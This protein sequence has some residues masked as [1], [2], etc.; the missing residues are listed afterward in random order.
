MLTFLFCFALLFQ[1]VPPTETNPYL[2]QAITDEGDFPLPEDIKP[3]LEKFPW[4]FTSLKWSP[5]QGP[6]IT[7]AVL[8]VIDDTQKNRI[9][10]VDEE[11]GEQKSIVQDQVD[12][13]IKAIETLL[14]DGLVNTGRF[15]IVERRMVEALQNEQNHGRSGATAGDTAPRH[16]Q[17]LGARF[18]IG[19]VVTHYEPNSGGKSVN[20]GFRRMG[21]SLGKDESLVGMVFRLVDAETSEILFSRETT[22]KISK[23]K[24]GGG[25][26]RFTR[27]GGVSGGASSFDKTPVAFGCKAAVNYGTFELVKAI[28]SPPIEGRV[29]EVSD[30]EII[31]NL[32]ESTAQEGMELTAYRL[33]KEMFDPVTGLS[34][35]HRKK[36]VGNVRIGHV[37]KNFSIGEPQGFA[38]NRL[39]MS[40]LLVHEV[41]SQPMRFADIWVGPTKKKL[42][43]RS[44]QEKEAKKAQRKR[45]KQE[46]AARK[47]SRAVAKED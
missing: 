23:R 39:A 26:S 3:L 21:L 11:T 13:P 30:E 27:K 6:K 28:G 34:L 31:I 41:A 14:I 46:K 19:A 43:S 29:V 20:L 18:L 40:D 8:P 17:F 42:I 38:A 22:V 45:K 33:G 24:I 37:E 10:M 5:Y 12:V 2:V 44:K 7:I 32:G 16:G 9:S 35:G 47:R 4:S 25:G 1:E 15:R 36:R